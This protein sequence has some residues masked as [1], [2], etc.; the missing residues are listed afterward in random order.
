MQPLKWKTPKDWA[1]KALSDFNAFLID[2]ASCER[3]ASA[4]G[5]SFV[6]RYPDRTQLIEPMIQFAKEELDHFHQVYRLIQARGL[7]ILRDDE[8]P[9]VNI[10]MK[11]VRFGREER[12][13]DRLLVSSL[14]EARGNE[15]LELVAEVIEDEELKHFYTKIARAEDSHKDLFHDLALLFF[16]P[17]EVHTRL[18]ELAVLEAEAIESV[19]YRCA[20]H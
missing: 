20:L 2:H 13:L 8:D 16:P 3:K 10:L 17:D 5:L 7:Q 12:F 9:Y 18:E 11:H 14:I 19:P 1:P 6:V 15:R 4:V